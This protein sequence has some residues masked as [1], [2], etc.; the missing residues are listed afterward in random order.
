[1]LAHIL[2]RRKA[3]RALV[4][5]L[6]RL[7][8]LREIGP[9]DIKLSPKEGDRF[10][11]AATKRRR[12]LFV[13]L[14]ISEED[15]FE[16]YSVRLPVALHIFARTSPALKS[17]WINLDDGAGGAIRGNLAFSSNKDSD[18][19]IPDYCFFN[20]NAY[21]LLRAELSKQRPWRERSD[22]IIWR[23]ATTGTG[24][25]PDDDTNLDAPHILPRIRLCAILKSQPNVDAKIYNCVQDI[26][27]SHEN[28]L[29]DENLFDGRWI[30]PSQW[31]DHK[32][33]VD[34]DGNA[35]AYSN[36]FSRLLAGCSVIKV[37]SPSGHRQWYYDRLEAW[38]HY[39]PVRSD[40]S[41]LVD[42]IDWCRRHE[43]ACSDIAAAGQALAL[44][45]TLDSEIRAT[46]RRLEDNLAAGPAAPVVG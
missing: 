9:R 29:R 12:G 28:R 42:V 3:R 24:S 36:L 23:G 32:Y 26:G 1:M 22:V 2:K 34:I 17:C 37:S 40:L 38:K 33:A 16:E 13:G 27:P 5:A 11:V 30:E 41:D 46:I 43:S 21:E 25:P 35:N 44:A 31:I 45:M 10:L 20:T 6:G 8:A 19:L 4:K 39:V 15:F 18:V 7:T 14:S